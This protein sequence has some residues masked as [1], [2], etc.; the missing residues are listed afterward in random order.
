MAVGTHSC[1]IVIKW[2]KDLPTSAYWDRLLRTKEEKDSE[3]GQTES[4]ESICIQGRQDPVIRFNI[5][6][7]KIPNVL[8]HI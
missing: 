7:N 6:L 1:H 4:R 2:L 3:P 8:C 5:I